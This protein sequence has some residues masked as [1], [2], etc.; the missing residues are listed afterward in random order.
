MK[1]VYFCK[2]TVFILVVSIVMIMQA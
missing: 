1:I 2:N